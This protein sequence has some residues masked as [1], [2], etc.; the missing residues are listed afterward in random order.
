[1]CG[2][3]TSEGCCKLCLAGFEAGGESKK[4]KACLYCLSSNGMQTGEPANRALG[5][6]FE[7]RFVF[8]YFLCYSAQILKFGAL[9]MFGSFQY[10]VLLIHKFTYRPP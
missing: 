8:F 1:M 4:S 3:V 9:F 10:N 2:C 5:C 7:G 6:L